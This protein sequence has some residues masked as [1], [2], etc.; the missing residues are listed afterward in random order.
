MNTFGVMSK[1]YMEARL[2][3]LCVLSRATIIGFQKEIEL[4]GIPAVSNNL[5]NYSAMFVVSSTDPATVCP[6]SYENIPAGD[7]HKISGLC[8]FLR[9]YA[10]LVFRLKSVDIVNES[11]EQQSS[12]TEPTLSL[13]CR[14]KRKTFFGLT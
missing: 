13:S 4:L 8:R 11:S 3:T 7:L 14:V 2:Q 1:L 9:G 12:R 10:S 6:E 5:E